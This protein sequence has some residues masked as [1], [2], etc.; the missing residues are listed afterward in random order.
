MKTFERICKN[1]MEISN[2]KGKIFKL[3]KGNM[4]EV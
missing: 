1:N 4:A 3:K 2:S